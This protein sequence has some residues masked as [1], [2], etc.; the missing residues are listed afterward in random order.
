VIHRWLLAHPRVRA[1]L[2]PDL[3]FLDQPGPPWFAELQRRCLERGVF[4]SLDGLATAL[5]DWI[6]VWNDGARPF[7]WT[8]TADQIIDRICATVHVS[9]NRLTRRLGWWRC[10]DGQADGPVAEVGYQVNVSSQRLHV[11]GDELERGH[12]AV[13]DLGYPGHA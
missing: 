8:K 1:A 13:L 12:L 9:P 7:K 2:H 10:P 4:C 11:P 6:R 3:L 5:E